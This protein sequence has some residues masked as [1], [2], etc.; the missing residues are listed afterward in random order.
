[1]AGAKD[2]L[3]WYSQQLAT[4]PLLVKSVTSGIIAMLG[5]IVA[6]LGGDQPYSLI[7]TAQFSLLG[8]ILVGPVLHVW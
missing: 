6:Q 8:V 5:D 4:R 2:A 7:R 3:D 1:M